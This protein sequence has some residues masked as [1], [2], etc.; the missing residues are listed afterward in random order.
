MRLRPGQHSQS[1]TRSNPIER[2]PLKLYC[3]SH[4]GI[5]QENG[6]GV[7]F[8]IACSTAAPRQNPQASLKH[9]SRHGDRSCFAGHFRFAVARGNNRCA[10]ENPGGSRSGCFAGHFRFAVAR[11]NNRCASAEPSSKLEACIPAWRPFMCFLRVIS[12]SQSL[13]AITAAPR[14]NPQASLGFCTRLAGYFKNLLRF[15]H[16]KMMR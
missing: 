11:G 3:N 8:E 2:H 15:F 6:S 5:S 13:A 7:R 16:W 14:Q 9:A 1:D 10:S 4:A 12:A